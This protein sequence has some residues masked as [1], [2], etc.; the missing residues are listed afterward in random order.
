MSLWGLVKRSLGF[1]WRTNLG[2]LLAVAVST[3]VLTGALVVGDSV[4]HSL[5]MMVEAR[6][7]TTEVALVSQNRFFRAEL[8]DDV[9]AELKS[10]V[11]PVLQLRG[12]IA[13]SDGTALANRVEVVGVDERF[14]E[15][16]AA[17]DDTPFWR[18]WDEGVVL[19]EPLAE[20][21]GV[22]VG[23]EVKLRIEKPGLMPSEVP[24]TPDSDLSVLSRP[25]V[26][27]VAGRREFGRFSLR[28]N[29]VSPLNVF[30]PIRWLQENLGQ[31]GQANV[32]LVGGGEGGAVTV[33][34][35]NAAVR[36]RWRLADSGLEIREL[37]EQGVVEV[38][39]RR[40]F[41]DQV[42]SKAAVEA[43]DGA[44]GILTYFV[45]EL[46]VGEKSTPYST[47]AAMGPGGNSPVDAE[48][49]EDEI[50]ITQWLADD[51]GA[52]VGD[53]LELMYSVMGPMRKLEDRTSSF[54]VRAI[55]DMNAPG[56]DRELMPA[57]PGL[58]DVNNCRDWKPGIAID[59]NKIHD[60]DEEYWNEYGGT[61]KAIIRLEAG[62]RMWANRYGD[63]TAVRYPAGGV[64][65]ERVAAKLLGEVDPGSVG[66][67]F[68]AVRERG[69]KAGGESAYF[70]WLFLG[71]SMFLIVAAVVLTGLLFVFGVESRG[72]QVGMLLA[73]GFSPKL[74][75][76]LLFLEG[77]LIALTG[78]VVGTVLAL[79]Y[80]KSMI[81]ILSAAIR[82]STM[83]FHGRAVS[84]IGGGL[85]AVG[86]SLVAIWVTLRKEG[87]RPARDL[88]AGVARWQFV[89]GTSVSR[90]RIGLGVAV[91][92]T[93]G[94]LALIAAMG[95][96]ES[97]NIAGVFF[98]AGAL[99]LTAGLSLTGA[100]LKM[101]AGAWKAPMA[102]LGSLGLRNAA[103]RSGRSM[104]VVALLGC[105]VFLVIGVEAFRRDPLAGAEKRSSGTGG[106]ALYG[107]SAIGI[108]HDLN[109]DGG[110]RAMVVDSNVLEGV[111]IVQFRVR[112]GDDA[113]CFNLN[114][115]QRPRLLG[116]QPAQLLNRGSFSF[117]GTM[118]GVEGETAWDLL[119]GYEGEDVVPAVG[120]YA[121][122]KWAL[123]KSLGDDIEYS[124]EKGRTFRVRLVGMLEN[125][126]LQGS[127]IIG[128]DQFV[129]RFPSEDGYRVLLI[130][131]RQGRV[132]SV[133]EHLSSRL[134]D[135]GLGLSSAK[136]RLAAFSEVENTYISIF[137]I[138]GGLGLVLG[139]VGLGLVVLR[140]TLD[141]RN[142]L[143][144]L[145][146]VGFNKV[147]LKRMVFYEH[148]GLM[149]GGLACGVV[150]ALVAV[151][152]ALRVPGATIPYLS[153]TV[154]IAAMVVSG[155][156]WIWAAAA[157]AMSGPMLDALRSE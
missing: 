73:V 147:A 114:R 56:L 77:G 57:F 39:S 78:A 62:R 92:A 100:L 81:W 28:A 70:G 10:E 40:I 144:M 33:E 3:A 112:E 97:S 133:A 94:A 109:S 154:T 35:A 44:V 17:K 9:A 122:I 4:R 141:R 101:A 104:A 8:A 95:G 79:L 38:R 23:D 140:N 1:Y 87:A 71:L 85:A 124:D 130:D 63:M 127:L 135:L 155:A 58:A 102:S 152:P 5:M 89:G 128:E 67:F 136:G 32:M 91:V 106:F 48:M 107:E 139:S 13:N 110:R 69:R 68:E 72:E 19:N 61:P 148:S 55:V 146:A 29:Q 145:R 7:G 84:L 86:I 99:L 42:L 59:L 14:F 20:R 45:N 93:A 25:I 111:E 54:E 131:A 6:L 115:A 60:E 83:S 16:G 153:L 82:G 27:A 64:S 76:R 120:D 41:I 129:K 21:L 156:I 125:S 36:K 47:V 11:A 24:L 116:V 50:L 31:D 126:I 34:Q 117:A 12:I 149:L 113:S 108:L 65:P 43:G 18:D 118:G 52:K 138:L 121:T 74:V 90:G 105:G 88:L 123:G 30:V 103:R 2:V 157:F 142:E 151:G 49:G 132:D 98:G 96:S 137:Q 26:R 51:L 75:R 53:R 66:L 46:R 150:A 143:A 37:G 134:S 22:A 80:T 119:D 15:I